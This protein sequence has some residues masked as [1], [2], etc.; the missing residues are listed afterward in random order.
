MTSQYFFL[1]S[2]HSESPFMAAASVK[3]EA[4]QAGLDSRTTFIYL[5]VLFILTGG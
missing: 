4:E 5:P 1:D 2:L 3:Q